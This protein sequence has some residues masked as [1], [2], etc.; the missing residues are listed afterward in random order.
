MLDWSYGKQDFN[1]GFP[2]RRNGDLIE[3]R[4]V[5]SRFLDRLFKDQFRG[6]FGPFNSESV[7]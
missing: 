2:G 5:E 6:N 3:I 1:P 4:A 7:K